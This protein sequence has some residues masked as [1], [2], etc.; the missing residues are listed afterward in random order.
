MKDSSL[1]ALNS[2]KGKLEKQAAEKAAAEAKRKEIQRKKEALA[3]QFSNAMKELGV[4]K[5]DL[6]KGRYEHPAPKPAPVPTQRILSD[7]QVLIDSMSD[8]IGI[9]HLL[10]SDE[11]LSYHNPSVGTNIPKLLYSGKWSI[12]GTLDLHGAT[13]DEARIELVAF[14]N[15][16][17]KAGHRAV[18]IIH[19]KGHGSVDRKPV[20]K[21]KVPVWLVQR[22]E[23]LAFVQAPEHDGGSGALLV[24]LAPND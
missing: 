7:K 8:E 3:N 11:R 4:Q 19:G 6:G 2:L 21:E 23:V 17:R 15:E 12:K 16:E 18:R 5:T 13:A 22:K 14:L 10:D 20:L 1:S 9:E 24:L